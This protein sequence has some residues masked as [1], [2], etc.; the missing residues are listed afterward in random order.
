MR[1]ID[2][3]CHLDF[4]ELAD[5]RDKHIDDASKVGIEKFVVPGVS[6]THSQ[7]LLS[8]KQQYTMCFIA[9]GL[10]PYFIEKHQRDHCQ[11][12]SEFAYE[13][14]ADLVAI[15]ECG[16]DTSCG[17]LNYQ[18]DIFK[19]QVLL[20]NSLCLP[21]IVHHRQ[22]HHLIAQ[23]FKQTPPLFGGVIHAFSGSLQQAHYYLR[24]NFK[25]G[26]G[27]T[28]TYQRARKTRAVV[29][30]LPLDAFVLETDAPFMPLFGYQGQTN[31]PIRMMDVFQ[32]LCDLRSESST[33]I[34]NQLYS[35]SCELF[36]I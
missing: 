8:F 24:H 28:I 2:S 9:A 1:F 13:H 16:I 32:H 29:A 35:T 36:R 27:G 7:S 17:D 22:S 4:P 23:V 18:T 11:R 34:A 19:Q 14:R 15:G 26:V 3:H 20:A 12:L 33:D 10:H 31:L 30:Q 6:L 5:A 21:L 25:L